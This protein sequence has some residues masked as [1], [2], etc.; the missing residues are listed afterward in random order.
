MLPPIITP[1]FTLAVSFSAYNIAGACT[2]AGSTTSSTINSGSAVVSFEDTTFEFT[3]VELAGTKRAF[4]VSEST[5]TAH[6]VETLTVPR[7]LIVFTLPAPKKA[8][9]C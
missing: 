7:L 6:I 9:N 4:I 3:G 8:N 5:P 2:I 1:I